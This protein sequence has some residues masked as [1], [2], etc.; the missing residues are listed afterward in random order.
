VFRSGPDPLVSLGTVPSTVAG[1]IFTLPVNLDTAA[2][3]ESAQLRIRFDP[4]VLELREVRRG[5]LTADF[6]WFIPQR[7]PGEV[8]VDASR[9]DPLTGGTGSL[10]DVDFLVKPGTAAGRYA[11]DLEWASL[12]EDGLTLNPAPKVGLD[13]TDTSVQVIA[14]PVRSP[15]LTGFEIPHSGLFGAPPRMDLPSVPT[16]DATFKVTPA[17][18]T[19]EPVRTAIAQNTI[20]GPVGD[21]QPVAKSRFG[22]L[23]KAVSRAATRMMN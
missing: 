4:S 18:S 14:A 11:V 6:D 19:A 23:L 10:F 3:L 16:I 1:D 2:G 20:A 15:R 12:N 7:S 21:E 22:A 9:M 5:S 17:A 13:P 8:V